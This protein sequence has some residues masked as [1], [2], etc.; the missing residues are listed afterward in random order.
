LQLGRLVERIDRLRI[1]PEVAI[2]QAELQEDP[3]VLGERARG[4]AQDLDGLLELALSPEYASDAGQRL[5]VRRLAADRQLVAVQ[6]VVRHLLRLVDLAE[7]RLHGRD[8]AADVFRS[9]TVSFKTS[10]ASS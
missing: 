6:G 3:R 4:A 1:E 2:G 7:G 10:S 9:L 5:T 8:A